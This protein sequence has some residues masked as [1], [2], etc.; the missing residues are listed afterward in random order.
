MAPKSDRL[1]GWMACVREIQDMIHKNLEDEDLT[2]VSQTCQLFRKDVFS[3]MPGGNLVDF[4]KVNSPLDYIE[5]IQNNI[6]VA[7][8]DLI[9]E[10]WY[11]SGSALKLGV[12]WKP[13]NQKRDYWYN[14]YWTIHDLSSPMARFIYCYRPNSVSASFKA[15]TKGHS[16]VSLAI[17]RTKEFDIVRILRTILRGH[18]IIHEF[19]IR[20]CGG[21]DP[22]HLKSGPKSFWE[23]RPGLTIPK[24]LA[25]NYRYNGGSISRHNEYRHF[26]PHFYECLLL[27]LSFMAVENISFDVEP[28]KTSTNFIDP[29][30]NYYLNYK[31][32]FERANSY[33]LLQKRHLSYYADELAQPFDEVVDCLEDF[34]NHLGV[35]IGRSKCQAAGQL[36]SYLLRM[37]SADTC[38][39]FAGPLEANPF[40]SDD[41]VQARMDTYQWRCYGEDNAFRKEIIEWA[42]NKADTGSA[43]KKLEI[44]KQWGA[45]GSSGEC[46]F[47]LL[48]LQDNRGQKGKKGKEL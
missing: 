4:T 2:A 19:N 29:E 44:I 40:S 7:N 22:E 18:Y 33:Y 27:P 30:G 3:R 21:K 47:E 6:E 38:N 20:F 17:L 8:L 25:R 9:A 10:P 45:G 31:Q 13:K 37:R 39:P 48:A 24:W 23:M 36:R 14:S 26:Y 42:M 34:T 28:A 11:S 46:N 15:A 41:R 12:T 43:F 16:I 5:E 32:L 35:L 1:P